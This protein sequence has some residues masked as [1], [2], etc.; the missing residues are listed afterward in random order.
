MTN[1]G[2][3]A[4][5]AAGPTGLRHFAL[6]YGFHVVIL[7]IFVFFSLATQHFREIGNLVS[8]VHAMSPL[9]VIASGLALVVIAGQLD[10]SVGRRLSWPRRSARS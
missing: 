6:R 10:I 3:K 4:S 2:T 8:L 9:M 5:L 1:T 7:A